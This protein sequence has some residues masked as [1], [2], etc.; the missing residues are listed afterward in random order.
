MKTNT[1]RAHLAPS[2]VHAALGRHMLVDGYDLVLD[3]DKS[4]GRRFYDTRHDRWYLDLFSCFATLPVGINHPAMREPGFVEKLTRAA[5]VNPTNSDIY[6]VEMA[7]FVET[8]GRLAMPE[9]LPHLFLVAGGTLGVENALKAAFDWKVRQNFR[10]GAREERGHQV[11]HFRESFHGRSGY[12]LS[13]TNT[14]DPRKYEYFPRFDWPRIPAPRLRF[15]IDA[16][17]IER[18]RRAEEESL[19]AIAAAFRERGDD[20]ACILIEPIQ[21]EGG[22]HHFRAEF[23]R[24]LRDLAHEHQALLI[25]DEVQTGMGLTGR[26]WAH[27]HFDVRP[28]LLAFGKKTQVCGMMG[29]GLLDQ[30]PENVFRVTSR[31]NS[32]WGGNLVDMVR[33]QRYLEIMEEEKLV[34]NAAQVGAHLRAA[35]ERLQGSRPELLSNARGRGLMCAID[36]PDGAT[37]DAVTDRAY[38]LGV[39]ILPCGTRSLRFRPPLDITAA[40]V[41]EGVDTLAR[42]IDQV[43]AKSA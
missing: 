42:A 3:L 40:E 35:L 39:I 14:A 31:I 1:P 5:I 8:F 33:C 25:F 27:Q 20:I 22:D 19:A 2:E 26:M 15:P 17:E 16:A 37:R 28:D 13:L 30:E 24:A 43:G 41:D 12:T 7:E 29:G 6:T 21:A 32:T 36:L 4:Q 10:R 9:Y 23:L 38:E 18:V 34:E 11:I